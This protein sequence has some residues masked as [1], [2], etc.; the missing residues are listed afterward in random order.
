[1]TIVGNSFILFAAG[2]AL[3]SPLSVFAPNIIPK[4]SNPA[5]VAVKALSGFC[6]FAP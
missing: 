1:M 5:F 4:I 2:V 3:G 6:S